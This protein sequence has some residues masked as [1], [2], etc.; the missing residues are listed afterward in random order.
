MIQKK[1]KRIYIYRFMK[2]KESVS[3]IRIHATVAADRDQRRTSDSNSKEY[4]EKI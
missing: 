1:S 2:K 4:M 3:V